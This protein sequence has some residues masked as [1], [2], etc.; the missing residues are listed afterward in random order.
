MNLSFNFFNWLPLLIIPTNEPAQKYKTHDYSQ[1]V[2]GRDY[3]FESINQ[4]LEGQMTGVG[5]GIQPCDYIILR[6]G[7]ELTRYQVEE[8]DYYADP[9]DMWMALLKKVIDNS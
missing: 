2:K 1:F 9:P 3:V 8:I 6:R 4:G 5:K 7:V